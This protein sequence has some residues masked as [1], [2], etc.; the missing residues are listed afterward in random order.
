M[1]AAGIFAYVSEQENRCR[2]LE[3]RC[4]ELETRCSAAEYLV[5]SGRAELIPDAPV[6]LG[7]V[8]RFYKVPEAR[9]R[10]YV[11]RGILERHPDS[12]DTRMLVR[13]GAV[14]DNPDIQILKRR[15]L[16]LKR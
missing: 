5:R 4:Q 13:L 1:T 8:A 15:K 9:I 14:M 6:S 10:D 12:T 3:T 16:N 7:W 2:E 11:K